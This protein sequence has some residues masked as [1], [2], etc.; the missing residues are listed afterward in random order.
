METD[1]NR[2][3]ERLAKG[4]ATRARVTG[5]GTTKQGQ[6]IARLYRKQLAKAIKANSDAPALRERVVWGALKG[7]KVDDLAIRLHSWPASP[8]P[9]LMT[10]AL[11]S[12][13]NKSPREIAL[14]IARN[15]TLIRDRELAAKIGAWGV[16]R[17]LSLPIFE[18]RDGILEL[19][20]TESLDTLLDDVLVRAIV[21]NPLLTPSATSTTDNAGKRPGRGPGRRETAGCYSRAMARTFL[22]RCPNSGQTVQDGPPTR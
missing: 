8:F 7:I 3:I 22:Y 18:E 6:A 14:W 9:T 20:L 15:L 12:E 21:A 13:G 10:S 1:R 2:T 16:N 4:E 5:F 17:L 19:D 11:T